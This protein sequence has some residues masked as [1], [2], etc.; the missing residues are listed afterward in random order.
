MFRCYRSACQI[1]GHLRETAARISAVI[2][3]RTRINA[4]ASSVAGM[5]KPRADLVLENLALRQQVAVLKNE[6]PRAQVRAFDRA[7][8][9]VLGRV[10]SKWEDTLAI[11]R[12]ETVVRWHRKGF[13]AFWHRKSARGRGRPRKDPGIRQAIL[14]VKIENPD[15]GAPKIHAELLKL[16]FDVAERT[17]SRYLPKEAPSPDAVERWKTFLRNHREGIAAMDFFTVPTVSF[18]VMYVLFVIRH[19]RREIVHFAVTS[20]PSPQWVIQQLREAFPFDSA[21]EYLI[22]DRDGTFSPAVID[23]VSS[24]GIKPKRT[25]PRSPWQNGVA[26]RWIGSCRREMI[27]HVVPLSRAHL[28]RLIASYVDFYNVGRCHLFLEKDSP[29]TRPRMSKPSPKPCSKRRG[30]GRTPQP[31]TYRSSAA[32]PTLTAWSA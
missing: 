10:W 21:P 8:W 7:F 14:R 19:D 28:E 20:Q 9:M 13:K 16:G 5:L 29:A 12:P 4:I 2:P 30:T 11:V 26:E 25:A 15:W 6:R 31:V 23:A 17:V 24:M 1:R 27:D 22:F 32:T 3:D 18:A